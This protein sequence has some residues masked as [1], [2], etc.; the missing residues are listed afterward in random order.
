MSRNAYREARH[1]GRATAMLAVAALLRTGA[2]ALADTTHS[3]VVRGSNR[4]FIV[5]VPPSYDGSRAFPVLLMFHGLDGTAAGAASSYYDWQ[6]TADTNRFIVAF[7]ESLS[8]AG[9]DIPGFEDYDGTGKRWDVAHVFSNRVDSQDVE[10]TG[11]ILDWMETNYNVRG[12][13][14]FTTGHSYGAFF[15]YYVSACLDGRVKAFAE[16]SGGL[17]SYTFILTF[18]WPLDVSSPP[19]SVPGFLL[20]SPGDGTVA[21]SNSVLLQTEMTAHGQTNLLVTLAGGLGHGWDKTKNQA[22]WDF[23]MAQT[24]MIDD[25]ADGMPDTWEWQHELDLGK[26]DSGSDPDGDG[27]SHLEEYRAGTDPKD[28]SSVFKAETLASA[29]PDSVIIRWASATGKTYTVSAA[30]NLGGGFTALTNGVPAT[31]PVNVYTGGS[32]ESAVYFRV[33]IP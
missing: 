22:Q 30:T 11:A 29:M 16:H 9:K 13:H 20:H 1:P 18:Y 23:F 5:H 6:A 14:V 21:Y 31:P 12:S 19:P 15:S 2:P 10:F 3:L 32:P 27:A 7:P 28:S 24:P 26:D 8:P 4:T 17:K 33:A 25:D